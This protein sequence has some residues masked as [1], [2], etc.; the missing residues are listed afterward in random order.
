MAL[1]LPPT[2][3]SLS[4]ISGVSIGEGL[5]IALLGWALLTFTLSLVIVGGLRY[6]LQGRLMDVPNQRSSHTQP[7]PRGGGLGFILAFAISLGI[8]SRLNPTVLNT[9]SPWLWLTVLPLVVI[10]IVDD[11]RHVPAGVRYLVQLLTASLIVAQCGVAPQPWLDPLGIVGLVL[12]M[13]LTVI[14][15]TALVNLYNFMD[16]MDGLVASVAAIQFGC[17]ALWS[18][19]PVLWLAVAS[20]L[21]F[22]Y[23]NWAP[24]KIFM[25]DAGSTTLGAAIALALLN[26]P[27]STAM[28]WAGLSM[29]LPLMGD[30]IYT[31][32]RRLLNRENIFT[33]HRTHLY[34][35]LHHQAKWPHHK[36]ALGYGG[37]TLLAALNL[38]AVGSP[39]A[40]LTLGFNIVAIYTTERYLLK[41]TQSTMARR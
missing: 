37:L 11:R 7:T 18:D 21:G 23:W 5:S 9:W 10:G 8:S 35:R 34:Q 13:G 26:Q 3:P 16:G 27:H 22:L 32:A 14:G 20:L 31:L 41:V 25:G 17:L 28:T 39:G 19:Q 38:Y 12:A 6:Y 40:I 24:A 30:A 15:I 4:L 36:V 1:K 33:A 29:L 2:P